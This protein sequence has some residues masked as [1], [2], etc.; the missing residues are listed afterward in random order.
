MP[1]V[2]IRNI[3]PDVHRAIKARARRHGRSTE[4]EIR[5]ILRAA[6]APGGGVRVGDELAALGAAFGGI[7]LDVQRSKKPMRAAPLV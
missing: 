2:T 6:A 3:P 1:T 7:E 5:E 4:A